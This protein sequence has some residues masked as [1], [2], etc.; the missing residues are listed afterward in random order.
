MTTRTRHSTLPVSVESDASATGFTGPITGLGVEP[1]SRFPDTVDGA[2][3]GQSLYGNQSL[4]QE[5]YDQRAAEGWHTAGLPRT[6]VVLGLIAHLT[7]RDVL[8]LGS[9]EG[10]AAIEVGKLSNAN[11]RCVDVSAVAVA[12]SRSRGLDAYQVDVNSEPLPF[13]D[14]SFDL[15]Y[16]TEVIEHL[17]RPDRALQEV[18]RVLRPGGQL[19]VS[20]PNLACLPNRFLLALGLQPLFS[21]VSEEMVV[22]RG[23]KLLGQGTSPVGHLRLYTLRG[24]VETLRLHDFQPTVIRGAAFSDDRLGSVQRLLSRV[25]SMAMIL[26][27]QARKGSR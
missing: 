15:V 1:L 27:V 7:V 25:P 16:L 26:V 4:S 10:E 11:V 19:I 3:L 21:E 22:G 2:L 9:G 20:T 13:N 6:N 23:A 8:D 14:E 17:V 12:S 18:R 24:L 5:F